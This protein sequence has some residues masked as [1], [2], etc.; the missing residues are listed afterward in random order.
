MRKEDDPTADLLEIKLK[1]DTGFLMIKE[2]LTRIGLPSVG[3]ESKRLVQSCHILHKRG[4]YFV[5]HFK[6]LLKLDGKDVEPSQSDIARRNRIA[7]LLE[8]WDLCEIVDRD[9]AENPVAPIGQIKVISFKDKDKWELVSKYN[10]G[11]RSRK[12]E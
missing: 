10:I 6:E 12:R 11:G 1:D 9:Q 3:D 2:T 5:V 7:H 8:E 4:R